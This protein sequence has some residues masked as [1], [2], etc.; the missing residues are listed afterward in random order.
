MTI[1]MPSRTHWSA[2]F[3]P[4]FLFPQRNLVARNSAGHCCLQTR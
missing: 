4:I 2:I 1:A 3:A